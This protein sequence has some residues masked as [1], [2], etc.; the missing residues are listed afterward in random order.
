MKFLSYLAYVVFY[1]LLL[2]IIY[3]GT[4]LM[5]KDRCETIEAVS[6][7]ELEADKKIEVTVCD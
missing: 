1:L 3:F 6:V 4:F 2:F 7:D 5:S